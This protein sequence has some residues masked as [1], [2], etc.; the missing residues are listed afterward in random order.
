[1]EKAIDALQNAFSSDQ[2]ALE[3]TDHFNEVNNS[4]LSLLQSEITPA[5]VFLPRDKYDVAKFVRL[6]SPLVLDGKVQYAIRGAGQQPV[7]GC[8]NIGDGGITLDLRHLTGI[9]IKEGVVALGA[10]ER[11]GKVYERLTEQGL[12]VTGSR[13][14]LGGIGGLALSGK[15]CMIRHR[16]ACLHLA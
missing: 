6:V 1:M 8:S 10:G 14:A 16:V 12:G 11:W 2:I 3:G 15:H 7:P 4:Y 9:E 5:V 13:S